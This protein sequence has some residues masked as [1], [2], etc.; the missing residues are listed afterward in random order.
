MRITLAGGTEIQH[1]NTCTVSPITG[2][3]VVH[4]EQAGIAEMA[5][6]SAVLNDQEK[7]AVIT[8]HRAEDDERVFEGYTRL[9]SLNYNG[10]GRTVTAFLAK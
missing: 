2:A 5:A 4:I 1:V 6:L 7:T 9:T 3:L 10:Q 8:A